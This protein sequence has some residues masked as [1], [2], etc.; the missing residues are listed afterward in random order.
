MRYQGKWGSQNLALV[1][2]WQIWVEDL[3]IV[4]VAHTK[5]WLCGSGTGGW[6]QAQS[7]FQGG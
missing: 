7:T 3:G 4:H 5:D 6:F 1:A 2:Q